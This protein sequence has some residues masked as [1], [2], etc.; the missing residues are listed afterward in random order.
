MTITT[1]DIGGPE[2]VARR[3]FTDSAHI[4]AGT[5]SRI[6]LR[7]NRCVWLRIA[8]SSDAGGLTA[9]HARTSVSAKIARYGAVPPV[10]GHLLERLLGSDTALVAEAANHSL[11]AL[12]SLSSSDD[13][14]G[15]A[16]VLVEDGWQ[17]IGLGST[18]LSHVVTIARLVGYAEIRA[19]HG[20]SLPWS[21]SI[22]ARFGTP[23][24]KSGIAHLTLRRPVAPLPRRWS[25]A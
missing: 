14:S 4:L 19:G 3:S 6:R 17:G 8:D 16:A 12:G 9:M 15:V 23:T 20:R 5:A 7:D 25:A 22:L 10:T 24:V 18:I 13:G 2:R 11:V 1:V 21:L